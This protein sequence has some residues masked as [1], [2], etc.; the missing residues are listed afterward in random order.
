M[1]DCFFGPLDIVGSLAFGS[2]A[3]VDS[4]Q[5]LLNYPPKEIHHGI[6][7]ASPT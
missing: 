7:N 1:C 4:L 2:L 5:Q 6:P 3:F